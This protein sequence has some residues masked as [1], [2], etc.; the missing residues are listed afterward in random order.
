[1]SNF[2]QTPNLPEK[3]ITLA[4]VG[5]YPEIISALSSLGIRTISFENKALPEEISRHQ[6]MLLCHTGENRLFLDPSE[7][8]APLENE[9]FS[10]LTGE[11]IGC[12]YPFD[13]KLNIAVSKDFFIYNPKAADSSLI[14]ELKNWGKREIKTKQGYT[15]C[16]VCLVT[17]NALITEDPSIY[18]AVRN[19]GI[20]A[21]LI[22]KGDIYLSDTHCGFLGG[23]TGKIDK[24]T[25][26]VTGSLQYHSDGNK[27][28]DFCNNHGVDIL[29]LTDGSITDIGGILPLK[30]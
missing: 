30:S 1:M 25:L 22:S 19:T 11:E 27:I 18:E 7:A 21:L 29:E 10:V 28:K 9:G 20:H 26:A 13:V 16:S 2:I 3:R 4:A 15:K 23:S 8:K 14:N 5:N 12:S 24:S 6:D 17:E